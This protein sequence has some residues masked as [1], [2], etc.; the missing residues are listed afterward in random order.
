[1]ERGHGEI[2]GARK[3]APR[4]SLFDFTKPRLGPQ[5]TSLS[6]CPA[7]QRIDHPLSTCY[8]QAGD[9]Y[10]FEAPTLGVRPAAASASARYPPVLPD[11][12]QRP[13]PCRHLA[14]GVML[15]TPPRSNYTVPGN[16]GSVQFLCPGK[17]TSLHPVLFFGSQKEETSRIR[18]NT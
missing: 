16:N 10:P 11:P 8:P 1:M 9:L 12:G 5:A 4:T 15:Q 2:P 14:P 17:K 18:I 3:S 6:P 13:N 7:T